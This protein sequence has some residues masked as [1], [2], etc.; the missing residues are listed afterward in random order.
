M[1]QSPT[2]GALAAALAK[3]QG[4]MKAAHKD[5]SN[6]FFKSKYADLAS[7]WEACRAALAANGLA[8]CQIIDG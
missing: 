7:V 2:I 3:S 4:A 1:T 5:A 6:P 8:V